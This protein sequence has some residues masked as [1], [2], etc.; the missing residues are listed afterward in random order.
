M[1]GIN[2]GCA[3]SDVTGKCTFALSNPHV[4]HGSMQN[5]A[6]VC[7]QEHIIIFYILKHFNLNY[8]PRLCSYTACLYYYLS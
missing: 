1:K 8:I 7:K 3:E 4:S 6:G 2:V 5:V